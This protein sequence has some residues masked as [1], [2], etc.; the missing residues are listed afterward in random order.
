[1]PK[2]PKPPKPI[3]PRPPTVKVDPIQAL[4]ETDAVTGTGDA[5]DDMAIWVNPWDRAQSLV[6]GTDKASHALEVYDLT[7][8]RL[9]RIAD[10]N[11]NVNNVDLRYNFPLNGHYVDIVVSSG[12]DLAIYKID[13][14]ARQL[15]DIT[16]QPIKPAYD[17]SG[18]CLYRSPSGVFY[19]YTTAN[20]GEVEQF[21]LFD[22]GYGLIDARSVRGP[23][24]VHPEP[25]VVVD[26]EIEACVADDVTGD[27]YVS[28]QDVAVWR[29]G[30]E[31]SASTDL[32][33]AV[34]TTYLYNGGVLVPDIE[35]IAVIHDDSGSYLLASSQGDST[36]AVYK[37]DVLT[38]PYELIRKFRI[39]GGPYADGCSITDGIDAT[40]LWLGPEF[41]HG[42]F[43]CQDNTNTLPGTAGTQ[44]FK[45]VPLDWIIPGVNPYLM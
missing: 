10:G 42:L 35:G 30:A 40:Q 18:V 29:Y 9:Q 14:V 34:V 8:H 26:G 44:D 31:P 27:L 38:A 13:P 7:G 21:E 5:A 24:D 4:F 22:D 23:W 16:A 32:R 3:G 12:S 28:E 11:N 33:T 41:P 19:A 17:A 2:P 36:F 1:M 20:N 25:V 39:T 6:I 45:F 37:L 15:V 43:I